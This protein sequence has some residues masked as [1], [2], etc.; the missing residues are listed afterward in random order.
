MVRVLQLVELA[1][2]HGVCKGACPYVFTHVSRLYKRTHIFLLARAKQ[3]GDF[4]D[5]ISDEV[6]QQIAQMEADDAAARRAAQQ[7]Q[8]EADEDVAMDDLVETGPAAGPNIRICP[9]CTFEN[10]HAG[11]DCE[12][13]G[14]PL[15]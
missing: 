11:T 14:L 3:A 5:D 4:D 15:V 6:R 12:V 9:H 13:C 7:L 10:G 1:D 2:I 8:Q